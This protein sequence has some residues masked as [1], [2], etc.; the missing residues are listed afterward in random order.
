MGARVGMAIRVCQIGT[1]ARGYYVGHFT[2]VSAGEGSFG[3]Y[4]SADAIRN[5][6]LDNENNLLFHTH[7]GMFKISAL[8][9]GAATFVH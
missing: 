1:P 6:A 3:I 8:V 7:T 5:S 9:R 2:C 4:E